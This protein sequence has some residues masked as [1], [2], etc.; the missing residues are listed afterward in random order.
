MANLKW[1]GQEAKGL[2]NLD[3]VRVLSSAIRSEVFFSIGVDDP[4]SAN[5]VAK[6]LGRSAAAVRYHVKTLFDAGLLIVAETRKRYARTESA[7]VHKYI[8]IFTLPPPQAP[9]Y[10][11]A[12]HEHF[13]AILRSMERAHKVAL[14]VVNEDPD[15]AKK[16][17]FRTY[18][19]RLLPEPMAKL[20]EDLNT[21]VSKYDPF[22]SPDGVRVQVVT[23]MSPVVA[24]GN[25]HLR[26]L[27]GT[28]LEVEDE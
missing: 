9:E 7:Y 11:R 6:M 15:Y 14:A 3:Q 26:E 16:M 22:A 1:P 5:E 4:L 28:S 18:Y 19:L 23:F 8:D 10:L 17:A 24:E 20:R 25:Q 12:M 21:L 13:A 27:T 2:M